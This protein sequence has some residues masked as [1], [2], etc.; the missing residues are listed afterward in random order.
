MIEQIGLKIVKI[1]PECMTSHFEYIH[2]GVQALSKSLLNFMWNKEQVVCCVFVLNEPFF[3]SRILKKRQL[4]AFLDA[5]LESINFLRKNGLVYWTNVEDDK[6]NVII[7]SEEFITGRVFIAALPKMDPL[8]AK[9]LLIDEKYKNDFMEFIYVDGYDEPI[10]T[11]QNP[12]VEYEDIKNQIDRTLKE[13]SGT[14][15]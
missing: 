14:S 15:S 4:S 7:E 5:K 3:L 13:Q 11:L 1:H 10:L 2:Q 8:I 12:R 9:Y 6:L